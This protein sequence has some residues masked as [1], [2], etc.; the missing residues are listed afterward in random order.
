M[1]LGLSVVWRTREH[2]GIF[3]ENK[4]Y[5]GD[6]LFSRNTQTCSLVLQTTGRP[7][8]I[9]LCSNLKE[10]G[11]SLPMTGILARNYREQWNLSVAKGQ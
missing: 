10:Q 4:G 11:I 9:C 1:R 8:L 7:S 2:V 3:L 6:F 5:L